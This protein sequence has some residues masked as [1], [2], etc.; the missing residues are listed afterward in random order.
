MSE[1]K[2]KLVE[3]YKRFRAGDYP[4]QKALY[5]KLGTHGQTPKTMLI[6]CS[7]SRADPSDIFDAYPGEMFVVRNVAAIVPPLD[8]TSGYH[9]TSAAIEYAVRNLN[10]DGIVVLGHESCGGV[11]GCLDGMGH[12]DNAGYV[13]RWVSL[14]NQV[15]DRVLAAGHPEEEVS[16]QM[17]L[18]TVRQSLENLMSF[19][20]VR[21]AVE[22]GSLQ[23]QG[24]YFSIIR[25][26][27]MF[28]DE[29]GEFQLVPEA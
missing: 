26:R 4:E 8:E 18:E 7:D 1:W 28:A 9:G 2:I 15:R 19:P 20:F 29:K 17:E 24:A 11:Q 27:L 14:I 22:S 5:E 21:E 3:G 16:Y 6:G 10:V 23:L 13:G 12:D 25:A